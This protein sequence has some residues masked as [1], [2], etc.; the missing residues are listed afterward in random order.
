MT[1]T[2]PE[3]ATPLQTYHHTNGFGVHHARLHC[4]SSLESGFEPA[5]LWPWV[6]TLPPA[7]AEGCE[8]AFLFE[9]ESNAPFAEF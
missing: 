5:S 6:R 2:T 7:L 3:L 1:R 8:F 9:K 4:S